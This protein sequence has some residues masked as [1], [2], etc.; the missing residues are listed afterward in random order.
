[1]KYQEVVEWL[2][3]YKKKYERIVYLRGMMVSVRAISYE[4]KLG[5]MKT[6][7][8]Y[9]DEVTQL[10]N[11][12]AAIEQAIDNIP[13]HYPRLVLGYKYLQYKSFEEIAEIISYSPI[14]I[15]R[16]HR[17]GIKMICNDM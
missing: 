14:Q 13:D 11:E 17:N 16:F 10:S 8:D 1:M 3:S 4:E 2:K 6:L 12:L 9:I 5:S 7:N 15:G